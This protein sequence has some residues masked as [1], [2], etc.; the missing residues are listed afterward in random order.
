MIIHK[1]KKINFVIFYND[2]Y[3]PLN[4]NWSCPLR[5]QRLHGRSFRTKCRWF[6]GPSQTSCPAPVIQRWRLESDTR[7]SEDSPVLLSRR[8]PWNLPPVHSGNQELN[9]NVFANIELDPRV[10]FLHPRNTLIQDLNM[11][12][13]SSMSRIAFCTKVITQ[14]SNTNKINRIHQHLSTPNQSNRFK[15]R[16]CHK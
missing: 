10:R 2:L 11:L 7:L 5:L 8:T 12:F 4:S 16:M 13:L 1:I 6:S 3:I 15:K 14:L 9:P